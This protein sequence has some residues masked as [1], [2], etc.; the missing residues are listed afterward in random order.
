MRRMMQHFSKNSLYIIIILSIAW[1]LLSENFSLTV[2]VTGIIISICCVFFSFRFLP[3]ERTANINI[4]RLIIYLLYLAGHI[5]LA[6]FNSIKLVF[7][8][9]NESIAVNVIEVK[10]QI[11]KSFLRT[12]LAISITLTPGSIS[13]D[14]KNDII[15]VL[16]L[17]EKKY[18]LQDKE[19]AAI[20]IKNSLEKILLK[21]EK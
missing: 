21:A 15:T 5:Y 20:S 6:A 9:H 18:D 4:F 19:K 2:A 17:S 1:V 8:G 7:M 12:M 14:L 3:A 11:S 13:L 10:T 16:L